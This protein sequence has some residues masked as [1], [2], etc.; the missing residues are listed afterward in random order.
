MAGSLCPQILL[1]QRSKIETFTG[2]L[3]GVWTKI[4]R[5]RNTTMPNSS[6]GG[7]L[8]CSVAELTIASEWPSMDQVVMSPFER[9][10]TQ[11]PRSLYRPTKG[12]TTLV[13]FTLCRPSSCP[14]SA[15]VALRQHA[16]LHPSFCETSRLQIERCDSITHVVVT[17]HTSSM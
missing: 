9:M 10:S 17:Y 8:S 5:L 2:R 4:W 12:S 7:E 14:E 1:P 16:N 11:S 13:R 15:A 3:Q 6:L